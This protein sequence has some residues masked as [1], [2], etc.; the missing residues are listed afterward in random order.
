M[1]YRGRFAP[2]PSGPLHFGSLVAAGASY[3]KQPRKKEDVPLL[4][5]LVNRIPSLE[6]RRELFREL[7]R[8]HPGLPLGVAITSDEERGGENGVRYLVDERAGIRQ[9]Q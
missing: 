2:T 8:R 6:T 9:I 5:P 3:F 1:T 4:H 7:V